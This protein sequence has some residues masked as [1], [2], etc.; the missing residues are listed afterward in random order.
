LSGLDPAR[1]ETVQASIHN[2]ASA[3]ARVVVA[4]H[5]PLVIPVRELVVADV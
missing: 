5:Q 1:S 4:S 3:G 2:F